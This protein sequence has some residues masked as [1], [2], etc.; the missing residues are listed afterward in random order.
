[1]ASQDHEMPDG[2]K[3]TSLPQVQED[4]S[5]SDDHRVE[6]TAN[7]PPSETAGLESNLTSRQRMPSKVMDSESELFELKELLI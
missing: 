2:A 5:S 3:G 4:I 1:M 6:T 7:V